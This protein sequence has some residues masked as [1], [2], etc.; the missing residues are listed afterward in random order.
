METSMGKMER[1]QVVGAPN[2]GM[3]FS[4][5]NCDVR[6]YRSLGIIVREDYGHVVMIHSRN[7]S[8]KLEKTCQECST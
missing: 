4:S 3:L 1:E 7:I 2:S 8:E 5:I 6:G